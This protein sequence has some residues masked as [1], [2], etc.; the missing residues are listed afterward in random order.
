MKALK[1]LALWLALTSAAFADVSSWS[2]TPATNTSID[3]VSIA[4]GMDPG[5][6]N[7]A[8]RSI[9]AA[10]AKAIGT[11]DFGTLANT[12]VTPVTITKTA[13]G[14]AGGLTD[15][16]SLVSVVNFTGAN[17]ATQVNGL[18]TQH[19]LLH[20]SGTVAAAVGWQG[21][22]ALGVPSTVTTTGAVGTLEGIQYHISLTGTGATSN[23]FVFSSRG[24]DL[25]VGTGTLSK[26]HSFHSDDV[27]GGAGN[28]RIT[29]ESY[30]FFQANSSIVTTP[31]L[32]AYGSEMSF[33]TGRYGLYFSGGASSV[34][35][36]RLRIGDTTTP[37]EFLEVAGNTLA[38]GS[39]KSSG[40]AGIGYATGAG[41]T[42]TQATS[43][44]TGVTLNKA[45]GQ[46]TLNNAALAASAIVC[47]AVTDSAVASTDTVV[48]NVQSGNATAGTYRVWAEGA[49]SG[50]FKIC[51]QNVSAG[52]LSEALVLNFAIIKAVAA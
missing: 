33:G 22:S 14:N 21:Y 42:V 38:T 45:S 32:A 27:S 35:S 36:G 43:K 8:D 41:G 19:N 47:F 24:P 1:F 46:V 3:G 23:A 15:W 16:R 11:A 17:G 31:I 50:S 37:T 10:I 20:S 51:D 25:N 40:T 48:V 26:F 2:S 30:G 6:L 29:T 4:E 39:I 34:L 12:T 5:N 9:M 52:S 7:D 18:N 13:S 28:N 44:S 49:A